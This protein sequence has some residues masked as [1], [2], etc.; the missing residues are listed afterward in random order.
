MVCM[1]MEKG[2]DST[3]IGGKGPGGLPTIDCASLIPKQ[4]QAQGV[5][6]RGTE[7]IQTRPKLQGYLL[8]DCSEPTRNRRLCFGCG[9]VDVTKKNY[10]DCKQL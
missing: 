8:R 5:K 6:F 1:A 7:P 10:P 4:H 3:N 2:R 9:Q